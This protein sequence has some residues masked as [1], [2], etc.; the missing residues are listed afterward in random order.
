MPLFG[1]RKQSGA[2][3]S[4][5]SQLFMQEDG[6]V[7]VCLAAGLPAEL[8]DNDTIVRYVVPACAAVFSDGDLAGTHNHPPEPH[9]REWFGEHD[10]VDG[11]FCR[12]LAELIL[13][14]PAAVQGPLDNLQR[15]IAVSFARG[16][17]H[18][19]GPMPVKGL[20]QALPP[21]ARV[22]GADVMFGPGDYRE[23]LDRP[24]QYLLAIDPG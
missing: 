13:V 21:L 2:A 5:G 6:I 11:V 23:R 22:E 9:L 14:P 8:L 3:G 15:R 4:P 20:Q 1:K 17:V 10:I 12:R 24:I 7:D 16:V 19:E 18:G